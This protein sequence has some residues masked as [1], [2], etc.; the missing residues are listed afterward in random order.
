M[1][2]QLHA[3]ALIA[4]TTFALT[5]P[6]HA[7][8]RKQPL[9]VRGTGFASV[10]HPNARGVAVESATIN[11]AEKCAP[12]RAILDESIGWDIRTLES[13]CGPGKYC[14]PSPPQVM[15]TAV[16]VCRENVR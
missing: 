6:V 14:R 4:A 16:F 15:A 7:K 8:S 10:E 5:Q 9:V 1:K 13:P 2:I 3:F 11:A 12:A